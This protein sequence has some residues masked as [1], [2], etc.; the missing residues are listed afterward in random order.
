MKEED[1]YNEPSPAMYPSV[2]STR[3]KT[4]GTMLSAQKKPPISLLV[5]YLKRSY[6]GTV[7]KISVTGGG[8]YQHSLGVE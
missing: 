4:E 5:P 8:V 2:Y 7:S 3:P 1:F 6:K